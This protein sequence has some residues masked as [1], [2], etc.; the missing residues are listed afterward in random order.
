[1]EQYMCTS[2]DKRD[3]ATVG[4]GAAVRE[5]GLRV[6]HLDVSGHSLNEEDHSGLTDSD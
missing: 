3:Q 4:G 6:W 5:L 2:A 1:M